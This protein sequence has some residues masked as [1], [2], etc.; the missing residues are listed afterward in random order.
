MFNNLTVL[1]L[2]CK[3]LDA[4]SLSASLSEAEFNHCGSQTRVS[5]GFS[6]VAGDSLVRK[7]GKYLLVVFSTEKRLMP[8]SVVRDIVNERVAYATARDGQRPKRKAITVIKEGVVR[9]LL[10]KAFLVRKDTVAVFSP[11]DGYLLIDSSSPSTVDK[12][13]TAL[14]KCVNNLGLDALSPEV[15]PSVSMT[16]WLSSGAPEGFSVD[17]DC[18]LK[19]TENKASLRFSNHSLGKDIVTHIREGKLPSEL[20][21]TWRDRVSFTLGGDMA[22][23]KVKLLDVVTEGVEVEED[24]AASVI[25]K[26]G[27]VFPLIAGL[28]AAMERLDPSLI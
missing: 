12:F 8:S 20:A 13:L 16:K 21:M 15:S 1:S 22:L 11:E 4:D 25:L 27:E 19:N 14:M 3:D 2:G 5:I 23:K 17:R 10:P 24:P 7:V 28:V 6:P 18:L 9:E 26:A